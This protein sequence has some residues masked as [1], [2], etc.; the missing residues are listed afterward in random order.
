MKRTLAL[1]I[2]GSI[3]T[4]AYPAA[5]LDDQFSS[6]R[7]WVERMSPK[8]KLISLLPPSLMF[9]EYD[10]HLRRSLPEYIWLIDHILKRNPQLENEE[11]GNIFASTVYLVEP[12][13]REALKTMEMNFLRGDL[14]AKPIETPELAIDALLKETRTEDETVAD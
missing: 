6:G 12:E 7:D 14:D 10:V 2:A 3:L 11:V 5:A 9:E 4:T 8:E 13:N 1:M